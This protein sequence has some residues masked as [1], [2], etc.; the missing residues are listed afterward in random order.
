MELHSTIKPHSLWRTQK[1]FI[2][3]L[4][5]LLI[6]TTFFF[7]LNYLLV[8]MLYFVLPS[9]VFQIVFA[10]VIIPK[11]LFVLPFVGYMMHSPFGSLPTKLIPLSKVAV[12]LFKR[13]TILMTPILPSQNIY[14][15]A[16][17]F[18]RSIPSYGYAVTAKF[19]P[20]RGSPNAL[21]TTSPKPQLVNPFDRAVLP[22]S[23]SMEYL[24]H[25]SKLQADGRQRRFEITPGRTPFSF[26]HFSSEV[27][28]PMITFEHLLLFFFTYLH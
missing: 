9:F 15:Y 16:I 25:S 27:K 11:S 13:S 10:Y 4:N 26:M 19:P 8:F 12:S 22:M 18:S 6:T 28:Q 20:A 3:I 5:R 2:M 21:P 1:S 7:Y 24:L 17:N 23:L 14:I